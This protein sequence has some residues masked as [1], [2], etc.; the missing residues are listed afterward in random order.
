MRKKPIDWKQ[1]S[2]AATFYQ[3]VYQRL[4][5]WHNGDMIHLLC[6]VAETTDKVKK[7]LTDCGAAPSKSYRANCFAEVWELPNQTLLTGAYGH[8]PA[9]LDQAISD[10][11]GCGKSGLSAASG[12]VH[13]TDHEESEHRCRHIPS[14]LLREATEKRC[15]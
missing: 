8:L 3:P 9:K 5:Q 2:V 13:W 1:A 15:R 14:R 6:F 4:R 10:A 11:L 7:L 12:L